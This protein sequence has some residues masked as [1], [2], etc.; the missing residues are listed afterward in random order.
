MAFGLFINA[1]LLYCILWRTQHDL[2][3]Y[4][5]MQVIYVS[6]DVSYAVAQVLIAERFISQDLVLIIFGLSSVGN[7][8]IVICAFLALYAITYLLID[9]N[10]LYR[11]WALKSPER[12]R[13]FS[14]KWFVLLLVVIALIFY[15]V[16]GSMCFVFFVPS[17]HGRLKLREVAMYKYGVDSMAQ[18]MIMGDYF[19]EGGSRNYLLLIG[20]LLL[21]TILAFC[22]S[23][24]IYTA[25]VYYL[26]TSKMISE[27][28][29]QLQRQL[30]TLLCAQVRKP[31]PL[32]ASY[33]ESS[34]RPSFLFSYFIRLV[35]S[36]S[37]FPIFLWMVR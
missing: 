26:K 10:F 32:L 33:I 1:F 15:I 25:I 34:S 19:H 31:H 28:G 21:F 35:S 2:G 7:S 29:M 24:M 37:D 23:F 30:F 11:L 20:V 14:E 5:Y 8:R 22:S 17:D 13:L 12:V 9:Y 3:A 18:G 27:K 36:T 6:I 4:K 16:W